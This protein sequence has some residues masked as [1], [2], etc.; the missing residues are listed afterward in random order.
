MRRAA[1][2]DDF[3]KESGSGSGNILSLV[4]PGGGQSLSRGLSPGRNAKRTRSPTEH[5]WNDSDGDLES[6]GEQSISESSWEPDG[7]DRSFGEPSRLL[8]ANGHVKAKGLETSNSHVNQLDEE[9]PNNRVEISKAEQHQRLSGVRRTEVKT[10][11]DV[12]NESSTAHNDISVLGLLDDDEDIVVVSERFVETKPTHVRDPQSSKHMPEADDIFEADDDLCRLRSSAGHSRELV[13]E[14][15]RLLNEATAELG[16]LEKKIA[17]RHAELRR[18]ADAAFDWNSKSFLWDSVLAMELENTF[19]IRYFRPLQ[20]EALNATLLRRDVYAILPTGAGKSLLYQLAAVVDRGLT[21]VITPLI[22]LSVDQQ[23]ALKALNI[24]AEILDSTTPKS[25]VK[26]IYETLLPKKGKVN[27]SAQPRKKKM[28][29]QKV[30]QHRAR[31][32][33]ED[34]TRDDMEASIL[35]VTPEQFKSKRLMNRI[36]MMYE[37]G[38]LSRIVV[39]EAHCCSSWGHDFRP[40]YRKLGKLKRQCPGTPI[41]ALSATSDPET[42][43]DVCKILGIPNT[44]IFRGSVDRPNLYYE[45]R[46]KQD[47]EDRVV[48][49]IAAVIQNEFVDECGIIYALSRRDSEVYS[50]GLQRKGI[51]TAYYHGGMDGASRN[52][53]HEKWQS[54]GFQVVVATIA[55]G[56]GIDNQNVRFVIHATMSSSLEG[57][58]QESGR[59]GRDGEPAKCILLHRAKD[60]ARLSGFVADKGNGRLAKMYDMYRYAAGYSLSEDGNVNVTCCR[61]SIIAAG[62]NE[63]PPPR[64]EKDRENCCDIC[65]NSADAPDKLVDVDVTGLSRN[66]LQ[67]MAYQTARRPDEKVT[68]LGLATAWGNRGERGKLIRGEHAAADRRLSL[69]L[70]LEIIIGL[71]FCGGLEEFHRHTSHTV[72]SYVTVGPRIDDVFDGS[73]KFRMVLRNTDALLVNRLQNDLSAEK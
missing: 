18:A 47:S 30:P 9:L 6:D 44:V 22:A 25:H 68:M 29:A 14:R 39:D 31:G 56:L 4:L 15:H 63:T 32:L 46:R 7:N 62:F 45:V 12:K 2:S 66:L 70:R 35:F 20:R 50:K 72:N 51:R 11:V 24:R 58:Y 65:A 16:L 69:S 38:H 36:E 53:V 40:E 19:K 73:K 60:F 57:Y 27:H 49:D 59:A 61:R 23:N 64:A 8:H 26:K 21:L 17:V 52:F 71:M 37:E 33:G 34:W 48:E 55:F 5:D 28:R 54:G 43:K 41:I 42:T 10:E 1:Q 3:E 13:K 67:I